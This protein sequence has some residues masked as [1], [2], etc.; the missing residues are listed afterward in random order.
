MKTMV[1]GD[2]HGRI[3]KIVNIILNNKDIGHILHL[4][5]MA[6]DAEN[7]KSIFPNIQVTAVDGNNEL[8]T[9]FP[10]EVL[11]QIGI[12]R[13]FATHGHLYGVRFS[14]AKLFKRA[15]ELK[16][17]FALFAH[18]HSKYEEEGRSHTFKS[19]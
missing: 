19:I 18:T 6:R 16:A 11:V 12:K 3:N 10:T 7:L 8:I 15:K 17:D 13:A 14:V 2:T 1:V 9:H 4:G 5:D